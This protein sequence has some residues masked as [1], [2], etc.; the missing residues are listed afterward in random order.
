MCVQSDSIIFDLAI[1]CERMWVSG[2]WVPL[3]EVGITTAWVWFLVKLLVLWG[4]GMC[5]HSPEQTVQL[6]GG[7]V[8]E[9]GIS[10]SR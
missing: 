10:V 2:P 4:A 7:R 5:S 3:C 8:R 1:T 9:A 6:A